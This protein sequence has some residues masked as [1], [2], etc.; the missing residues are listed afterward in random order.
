MDAFLFCLY[1]TSGDFLSLFKAEFIMI[2]SLELDLKR[3]L[4]QK[5]F[6]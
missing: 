4:Q 6:F 5:G 3:F 1:W 2:H